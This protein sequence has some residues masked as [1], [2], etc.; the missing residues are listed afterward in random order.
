MK[1]L[2]ICLAI[3]TVA[4]SCKKVPEGG[5]KA[6]IKLEDGVERYSDDPQG[7][8]EAHGNGHEAA[9]DHK[10]EAAAVKPEAEAPKKD[11]DAAKP[12]EAE[13]APKAEH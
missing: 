11:S 10:E 2:V 7:G 5:N 13:K 1:K 3:A 8:A 4:V 9:A 12:A 6:V